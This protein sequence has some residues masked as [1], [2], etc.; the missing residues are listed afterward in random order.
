MPK[1]LIRLGISFRFLLSN[2]GVN[3][4]V[5]SRLV[6]GGTNAKSLCWAESILT[7]SAAFK[8]HAMVDP[9]TE[10]CLAVVLK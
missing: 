9:S 2:I 7:L 4:G 8:M 3:I 10:M 5:A 6:L 1:S